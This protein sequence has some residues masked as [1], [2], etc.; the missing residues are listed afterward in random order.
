MHR[1]S[2][3]LAPATRLNIVC[4]EALH[5]VPK[6]VGRTELRGGE[7]RSRD[8]G[9]DKGVKQSVSSAAGIVDGLEDAET[10]RQL[11]LRDAAVGEAARSAAA[12]R[13]PGQSHFR[14][15]RGLWRDMGPSI[16]PA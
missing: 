10:E 13:T 12:A 5:S 3:S 11:L 6:F 16:R 7:A 1:L 9:G 2:Y 15:E 8:Q 14:F 4:H